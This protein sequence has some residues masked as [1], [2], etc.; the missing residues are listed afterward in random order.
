MPTLACCD[1]PQNSSTRCRILYLAARTISAEVRL[2]L[3]MAEGSHLSQR[4]NEGMAQA[5]LVLDLPPHIQLVVFHK[6]SS[7]QEL[8]CHL[9]YISDMSG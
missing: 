1:D 4:H 5:A 2:V 7:G 8:D 9:L 6:V 3:S